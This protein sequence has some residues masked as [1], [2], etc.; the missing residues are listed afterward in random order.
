MKF[1]HIVNKSTFKGMK[2]YVANVDND[3][4]RNDLEKLI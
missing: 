2:F 3:Y 4:S 1:Q